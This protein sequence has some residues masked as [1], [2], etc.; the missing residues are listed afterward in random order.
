MAYDNATFLRYLGAGYDEATA[1]QMAGG[2]AGVGLES[3]Y[4]AFAG[5]PQQAAIY[6]PAQNGGWLYQPGNPEQGIEPSWINQ[7]TGQISSGDNFPTAQI[8]AASDTRPRSSDPGLLSQIREFVQSGG[9]KVMMLPF[10]V[11]GAQALMSGAAGAGTL[12]GGASTAEEAAQLA[13]MGGNAADAA[14]IGGGGASWKI[15]RAHV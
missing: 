3:G 10:A 9:F 12:A 4:N 6:D 13:S 5:D 11:A 2:A 1:K 14:G 8:Q 7:K 15:G